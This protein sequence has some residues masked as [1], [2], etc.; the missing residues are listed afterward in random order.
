MVISLFVVI[1][2]FTVTLAGLPKLACSAG[3]GKAVA[4]GAL[5][6]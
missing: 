1:P 6:T 4:V 2:A 3:A 5:K